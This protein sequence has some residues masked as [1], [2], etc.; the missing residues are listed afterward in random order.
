MCVCAGVG[1][2][3]CAYAL[4]ALLISMQRATELSSAASLA[5]PHFSTVS[6]HKRHDLRKE[7]GRKICI[8]VF[9]LFGTFLILSRSQRVTVINVKRVYVEYLLFV[10]DFN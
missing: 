7:V 10:S 2:R 4:V 3:A 5:P 6:H 9:D 8:L 1:A